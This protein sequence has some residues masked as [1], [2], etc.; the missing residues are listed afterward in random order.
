MKDDGKIEKMEEGSQGKERGND[1]GKMEI[2]TEMEMKEYVKKYHGEGQKWIITRRR[3]IRQKKNR[4]EGWEEVKRR[5]KTSTG[6][7][8]ER[9]NN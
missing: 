2:E 8:D 1:K 3:V 6:E 5:R 4:K 7:K 9:V